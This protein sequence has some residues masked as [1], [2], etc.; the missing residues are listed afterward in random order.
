ITNNLTSAAG[1]WQSIAGAR[2]ISDGI[3]ASGSNVFRIPATSTDPLF[4]MADVGKYISDGAGKAAIPFSPITTITGLVA[5]TGTPL[6]SRSV[7]MSANA[8]SSQTGDLTVF[9][10]AP[11]PANLNGTTPWAN[12]VGG[13]W[14]TATQTS[15]YTV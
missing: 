12:A 14:S 8:T 11:Q 4:T 5:P 7:T 6:S 10:F 3:T 13:S 9:A 2:Q 15:T 1:D